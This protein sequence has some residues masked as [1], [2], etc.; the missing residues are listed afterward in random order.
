MNV[1]PLR[2]FV[3]IS[4]QEAVTKTASGLFVPT[5]VDEKVVSGTILAVGSGRVALDGSVIPM[6]VK[7]GQLVKFNKNLATEVVHNEKTV[8]LIREDQLLCVL[9]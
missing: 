8:L 5:T 1:L 3:V 6:E 2:D 9:T 7:V 4:K